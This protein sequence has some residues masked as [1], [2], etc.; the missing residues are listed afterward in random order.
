MG[1][2]GEIFVSAR[3]FF[4]FSNFLKFGKSFTR[5]VS[6]LMKRN[7]I[8][9]ENLV[10]DWASLVVSEGCFGFV[11]YWRKWVIGNR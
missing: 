9:S 8:L 5:L 2:F 7:G 11:G 6:K 1:L 10:C 4:R 3:V